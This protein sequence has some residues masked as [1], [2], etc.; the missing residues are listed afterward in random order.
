MAT[1]LPE[2]KNGRKIQISN[3]QRRGKP[4]Y[5]A[6]EVFYEHP[7]DGFSSDIWSLGVLLY[8]FLTGHP[9]YSSPWDP[10]YEALVGGETRRLI[11]YYKVCMCPVLPSLPPFLPSFMRVCVC[12]VYG[13]GGPPPA[14]FELVILR[15]APPLP[16]FSLPK[17]KTQIN[18]KK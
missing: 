9:L 1:R 13:F 14:L 6:P 5:V 16:R 8:T 2:S 4:G 3:Q 18:N 17:N 15:H 12:R 11:N 7:S 10:A